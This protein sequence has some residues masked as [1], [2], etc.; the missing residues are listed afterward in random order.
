VSLRPTRITL[1]VTTTNPEL[2]T[3][4]VET[5]S[6]ALAGLALEGVD[7][8]LMVYEDEVQPDDI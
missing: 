3:R 6:R 2:L 5:M 8:T 4:A 1:G 7:A